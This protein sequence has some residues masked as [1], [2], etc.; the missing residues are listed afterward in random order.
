ML[1]VV[2]ADICAQFPLHSRY[3]ESVDGMNGT[4][5]Q[6]KKGGDAYARKPLA[7]EHIAAPGGVWAPLAVSIAEHLKKT[8][9][10]LDGDGFGEI[11]G[12]IEVITEHV[13]DVIG[14]ELEVEDGEE[15]LDEFVAIGDEE[16]VFAG[17]GECVVAV[18]KDSDDASAARFDFLEVREC[19]FVGGILWRDDDDGESVVDEG[20]GTVFHFA[21]GVG[22][23]VN[24]RNFL[25]FKRAFEGD[26]VEEI[27]AEEEERVC[28]EEFLCGGADVVCMGKD[29]VHEFGQCAQCA[30]ML[31]RVFF[32]DGV[33][34]TRAMERQER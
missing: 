24:V 30:E 3:V 19:F 13:G 7:A 21:G 27:S 26:G 25:E 11:S 5:P 16:G 32:G 9:Q 22:F 31:L 14:E 12:L 17:A 28:A 33:A 10:S 34:F 29:V 18:S 15:G 1:C 4:K 23:G 2:S 8:A 6:K 20:N